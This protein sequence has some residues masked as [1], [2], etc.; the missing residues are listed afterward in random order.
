L[1]NGNYYICHARP[2]QYAPGFIGM[3]PGKPAYAMK[4]PQ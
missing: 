4:P 3:A 2:P 1:K